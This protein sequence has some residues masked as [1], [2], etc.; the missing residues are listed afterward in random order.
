MKMINR[1]YKLTQNS[2]VEQQIDAIIKVFDF[3]LATMASDMIKERLGRSFMA[4]SI[5][6]LKEDAR[7][8]LNIAYQMGAG[9]HR[10]GYLEAQYENGFLSLR[11]ITES[12]DLR[13]LI[14]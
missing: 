1:N 14:D 10:R 7:N 8:L 3:E 5:N 6:E 12:V 9:S 4:A 13:D 2:P 11:F